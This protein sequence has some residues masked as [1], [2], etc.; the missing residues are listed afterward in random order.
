VIYYSSDSDAK[1]LLVL[2][3]SVKM[4]WANCFVEGKAG[5]PGPA[6]KLETQEREKQRVCHSLWR[7]KANQSCEILSRGLGM[8]RWD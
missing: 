8:L 3:L 5:L 6:G 7:K 1:V 2:N 4:P